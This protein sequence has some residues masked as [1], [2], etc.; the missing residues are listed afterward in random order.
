MTA[1]H[2]YRAP[3]PGRPQFVQALPPRP[4]RPSQRHELQSSDLRQVVVQSAFAYQMSVD[5]GANL[6]SLRS[7]Q[8]TR[9]QGLPSNRT[10]SRFAQLRGQV[11]QSSAVKYAMQGDKSSP[12]GP[13]IN[14]A[15]VSRKLQLAAAAEKSDA[16]EKGEE[17]QDQIAVANM[18]DVVKRATSAQTLEQLRRERIQ[19]EAQV[20]PTLGAGLED[21][22]GKYVIF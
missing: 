15:E 22:S 2:R 14:L 9:G 8:H 18:S 13:A 3:E 11:L 16:T 5:V 19:R 7:A 1:S 20:R 10:A 17:G 6:R 21:M 12:V 4:F